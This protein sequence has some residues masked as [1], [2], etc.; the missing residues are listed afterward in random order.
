M[1]PN[2]HGDKDILVVDLDGTLLRSDMLFETFWSALSRTRF[3]TLFSAFGQSRSRAAL[4]ARLAQLAEVSLATLPYNTA[5]LAYLEAWRA[6]GGR[7]VLVSGSD[8]AIAQA[9]AAHTGLFDE[10]HGS[11]GRQNLKGPRKAAFL[12]ERFPDGYTYMGDSRADLSV[13][14]S[15]RRAITVNASAAV[16]MGAERLGLEVEHLNDGTKPSLA[17]YLQVLRPHQWLKNALVFLPM[18]LAH[19]FTLAAATKSVGALVAF[20]LVASSTYTL[21]DLLDL[22]ADRAHPRKRLRPFASGELPLAH[23]SWIA[24]SCILLG[25]VTALL[26]GWLLLFV[27]LGYF[28]LST[29]YSL[30][31]KRRAV[32]DIVVLAALYTLRILGGAAAA[33]VPP[34]FWLLAFSTFIFLS[35]AAV[36]RQAEL[37]DA[38]AR[39]KLD[40]SGRGYSVEDLP[41]I[42]VIA[43]A[44]GYVAVLV[45]ALYVNSPTV[46]LLYKQPKMLWGICPVLLLW[47]T[48]T[49]MLAH[50]G[51]MHDDP[52]VFALRD[53]VSQICGLLVFAFALGGALL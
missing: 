23:G 13:W 43:L 21:N 18:L 39:G 41:I 32:I 38:A 9:I 12:R 3:L 42:S 8:R 19:T 33:S 25:L 35:L 2:I 22:S 50:R 30:F 27:V 6:H 47:V 26:T 52:L 29:A 1:N 46:A 20:S 48:R 10:A 14:R 36:K 11:D 4:K 16:R 17:T 53:R 45:M 7:T 49:V 51:R 24:A 40:A 37:V 44:A 31:F 15:A 28:T 34:S 5:V